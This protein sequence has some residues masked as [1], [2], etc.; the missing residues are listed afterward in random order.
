MDIAVI[1]TGHVGL[2]TS[3]TLASLGHSVAATDT[4]H[5]KI[6]ALGRGV[7]PFHEP[8]LPELL[9]QH[10]ASG[11]VRFTTEA[12]EALRD[13]EVAFICV[14]TPP[15]ADGS[16]NIAAVESTALD[17]ARF[18]RPGTV[19]VEKST[20]PAG[21]ADRLKHALE[22]DDPGAHFE[23]VSNPEFLREGTAIRDSLEP[24]RILIGADSERGFQTMREVYRPLV[25]RRIKLVETD[26][27][28]AELAKHACNAFLS[29][30][31]SF[32][33]GLA[34]VCELAGADVVRVAEVMGADGRIGRDFLDAGIGYGG[35]CF[36]KDL[37]A[38]ER[39]CAS[40]GYDFPLLKDVADLN[41]QAA[42][43]AVAKAG[44]ALRG[45]EGKRVAVLGLSYKPGTDDVRFSP[46][47]EVARRLLSLEAEVIGHDPLANANAKTELPQLHVVDDPYEAVRGA[48]CLVVC[49]GWDDYRRLDLDRIRSLMASPVVVDGRNLFDP[50]RMRSAGVSYYPT[51]RRPAVAEAAG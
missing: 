34:R 41:E 11:S 10:L 51:G 1:G 6:E 18:A 29:L 8:E 3:L 31:I 21:T 23:V 30:K 25:E 13:A 32:A 36:P 45:I 39:F 43:C 28:T 44:V 22:R 49:T 17:V 48:D 9:Q 37:A 4:D 5:E 38:F 26:I 16:A 42:E 14:G 19:I 24:E 7:P 12:S 47:L 33:N 27:H 2:V 46:A 35:Y 40:I 20:V 50:D 15:E